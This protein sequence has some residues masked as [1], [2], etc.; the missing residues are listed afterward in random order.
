[1]PPKSAA[2]RP[3][4]KNPALRLQKIRQIH[5]YLGVFFA[6]A[7]LFFAGTGA[8]QAFSLHEAHAGG[9]APPAVIEK[10]GE[11]HK[12]QKFALKPKRPKPAK[13]AVPK[14]AALEPAIRTPILAL[15]WFFVATALGLIASTCLGLWMGLTHS[16]NKGL[17]FALLLA[18]AAMPAVLLML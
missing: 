6:P 11:V 9:Y 5:L 8:L 10:L 16:R 13:A 14:P 7:L 3:T 1:M 4:R 2:R 15:K 17:A 18:G 12:N